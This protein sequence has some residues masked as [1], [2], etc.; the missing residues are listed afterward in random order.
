MAN[1]RPSG[2][3]YTN[4]K[5]SPTYFI[6]VEDTSLEGGGPDLKAKIWDGMKPVVSEWVG[7]E[8][9]E[10]SLYGIRIYKEGAMLATRK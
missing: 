8:I 7:K 2:N 6:S 10:T 3:T 5:E 1:S 4:N 9:I